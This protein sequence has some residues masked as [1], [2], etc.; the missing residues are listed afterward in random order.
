MSNKITK[1]IIIYL[2]IALLTP[3]QIVK[4]NNF[5]IRKNKINSILVQ[6]KTGE[7]QKIKI[8]PNNLKKELLYYS[9]LPNV[10]YAEPNYTYYASIIPTDT[11]FSYQWYLKKIKADSAWDKIREAPNIVIAVIDSGVQINHPDIQANIWRN[12]FEVP[13]NGIDDDKNGY[14]DDVNGWDFVNNVPDPSPK[15]KDGFTEEGIIH[16]TVVAGIIA[17]TGNNAAGVAGINWKAQIMPLKVLDDNGEGDTLKVVKAIDYAVK[18]GADI[19]NL[20]FVGFGFSRSLEQAIKRAYE[21]GVLIVAA[22]G[23]EQGERHGYYLDQT[24]MYPVCHDGPNGENW[25]IGVAATDS[26]DQK[27]NFSSYGFKCID[28]S[29][30]G[31]SIY[32]LTVFSPTHSID[33]V[34]F[35][36]YYDG[37]WSGTS[38]A[39]PMVAGELALIKAANP[40]LSPKEVTDILLASADDISRLN[41]DYIGRLGRGRINIDRAVTWALNKLKEKNTKLLLAPYQGDISE[42]TIS[43]RSGRKEEEFLAYNK[44]FKG[45]VRLA[46]GDINGDGE[47]EIITGAGK[48]GGPHVRIFNYKGEV[49][50]QFFAYNKNFR[51]GV[52]VAVGDIDGDGKDEIITGAGPG[53]GPQVRIFDGHGKVLGQFFA[54][55]K[56][57]R[58]GVIVAVGNV[59]DSYRRNRDEII[60][61]SGEGHEPQIKIFDNHGRQRGQFLAFSKHFKG[62]VNL[63]S[64]DI[65]NDGLLEIIAA[66][67]PG[68]G[69]HV[70]IFKKNGTLIN[71]FYAYN[72]HFGGGVSVGVINFKF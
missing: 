64:G 12:K 9:N 21:A 69:P 57:F 68:G 2:A 60:T 35:N 34:Y 11:F 44:N 65:D 25:V 5:F 61:S 37:Y 71:S 38:M 8:N 55:N 66:A 47:E 32:N 22:G 18:N 50:G 3:F 7:L 19:I 62:I 42:V 49:L 45:G 6:Y 33:G 63:V 15:F 17:A 54:Y 30:P 23:N 28:I 53:G 39:T 10:V 20:S 13:N 14:V 51:G 31:V 59:D 72:T 29:A 41:P 27:A 48:G 52:N 43:D 4:A 58:S 26:L 36:K 40:Q 1:F 70:R 46:S 16:G 67:G 24:P 56:N